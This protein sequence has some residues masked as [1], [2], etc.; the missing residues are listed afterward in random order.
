VA[1][2]D[3]ARR[4]AVIGKDGGFLSIAPELELEPGAPLFLTVMQ[5]A[6][7]LGLMLPTA[8]K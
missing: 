1:A 5:S 7:V 8:A 3:S 4:F 2:G 6:K